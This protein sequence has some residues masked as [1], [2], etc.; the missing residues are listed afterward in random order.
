[1]R[2]DAEA[3]I[4]ELRHV[5]AADRHEPGGDHPGHRGCGRRGGRGVGQGARSGARRLAGDVEQ[6]LHADGDSGVAAGRAAGPALHVRRIGHGARGFGVDRGEGGRPLAARLGDAGQAGLG[7]RAAGGGA[8]RQGLG[9]FLDGA[10]RGNLPRGSRQ[11][12]E[13]WT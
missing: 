13:G 3:G 1:M 6:V 7:Q 12:K 2:V 10:H 5:G 4:G 9:E 8:G 11:D